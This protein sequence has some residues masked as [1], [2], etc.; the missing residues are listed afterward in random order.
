MKY[1]NLSDGTIEEGST[2]VFAGSLSNASEYAEEITL[3]TTLGTAET[4]DFNQTKTTWT[5][6]YIDSNSQTQTLS[7]DS[8]GKFTLP[9]GITSFNVNIP[10]TSD[11]VYEGSET[12][13]LSANAT[14]SYITDTDTAVGTIKDDGTGKQ[15]R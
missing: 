3:S 10:T 4:S 11:T 15:T 9:A 7:V 5:V 12:F 1:I 8:N 13:S 14:S 6:T 2:I